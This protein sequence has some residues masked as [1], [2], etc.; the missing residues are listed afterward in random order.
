MAGKVRISILLGLYT[1]VASTYSIVTPIMEASDE[2]WHYPMVKYVADHGSLPVQEPG[3]ET[4]WRQEGS[5]APLY[6]LLS[7]ALTFWI[8]T[9]DADHVRWENPHADNGIIRED[10]NTNLIIHRPTE[11]VPWRG[12]VLAIHVVRFASVLMGAGAVY[13]THRLVLELWPDRAGLAIAA[14][15]I[16]AS[17]PMFCFI[18]GSVN[19]DNLAMLTSAAAIWLLVRLVRHHSQQD[20]LPRRVWWR[21]AAVLGITLGLGVLTKSQSMGLLL[22]TALAVTYVA[23]RQRSRWHLLVGGFVTGGLVILIA[24]WWFLRNAILYDGDWAGIERFILILGYRVPPATLRQLWGERQG[25]MMAYWGLFGGVNLPLPGWIYAALNGALLVS[26]AGLVVGIGRRVVEGILSRARARSRSGLEPHDVQLL[27]VFLWPAIAFALWAV[28]ARRTWSSQGRLVFSAISAWSTWMAVGLSQLMPRRWANVLPCA[29]GAF[30]LAVA[31]WSP[32]GVIAPAYRA[33]VLPAGV[34]PAPSHVL[35]ANMGGQL[36]LLGY[37]VDN[38]S[39]RPGESFRFA[40]YWESLGEMDRN[41]SIFSHILDLELEVPVAVR[42]RYPGEGLMATSLMDSGTRW[43]DRY[44]VDLPETVYAPS[45]AVLEVG[46]YDVANG[47]RPPIVIEQ[48]E[49]VEVV[50]NGLRFQPLRVEPRPGDLPNSVRINF[51]DK[52]ALVGWEVD[53][54]TAA[55]GE[56]IHLV[57]YWESLSL[58]EEPY[59]VSA[60][61]VDVDGRKAAQWDSWP[62]N[63]DT[64]GWYLGQQVEDERELSIGLDAP[65]GGYDLVL[66]VYCRETPE[67]LRL[68]R[69]IDSDGRVLSI[70]RVVLGKVRIGR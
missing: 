25:F 60:Q 18:T 6:Y 68:L 28:W 41:W 56:S 66:R 23:R 42:D 33:P 12:T 29:V 65:P 2:L 63:T 49:G 57:T 17:N 53:G 35:R 45:D 16:T 4:P 43:V 5:Q 34:D 48:G 55:P 58:L 62:G 24:G 26:V 15:A 50:A 69:T 14:A 30:M 67:T 38:V 44:V 8:D 22:V 51:E 36:R 27:L 70:D 46:L 64:S 11:G 13:L 19:N 7:A 31:A 9:S 59:T 32:F 61:V 3:V 40:L 21:D 54:R 39:A 10:G 47:E 37:D 20:A 1:L 52:M